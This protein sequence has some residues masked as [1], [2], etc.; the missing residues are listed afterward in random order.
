MV[1]RSLF[2]TL[3]LFPIGICVAV[4]AILSGPNNLWKLKYRTRSAV[5]IL[6]ER[7]PNF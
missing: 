6:S 2:F 4:G 7:Q 5:A 1:L 3:L